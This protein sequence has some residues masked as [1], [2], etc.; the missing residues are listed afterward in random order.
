MSL[1]KNKIDDSI[2]AS[3]YRE[4]VEENEGE[5]SISNDS[6]IKRP[7][8][9]LINFKYA[10]NFQPQRVQ[11]FGSKE[12]QSHRKSGNKRG[13]T[14]QDWRPYIEGRKKLSSEIDYINKQK[15]I[16]S[17]KF[18]KA[19]TK[20]I[21]P[22]FP[23]ARRKKLRLSVFDDKVFKP[24]TPHMGKIRAASRGDISKLIILLQK[25]RSNQF[26]WGDD[27]LPKRNH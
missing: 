25:W 20:P 5:W 4:G 2:D 15:S 21:K 9:T 18:F 14:S 13:K 16:T 10:S 26:S 7:F 19:P 1:L 8:S 3:E 27:A 22:R 17:S 6:R 11:F 12:A 23:K 24:F